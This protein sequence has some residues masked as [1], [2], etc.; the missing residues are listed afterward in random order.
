[1]GTRIVVTDLMIHPIAAQQDH[2]PHRSSLP[3][4]DAVSLVSWHCDGD[5]DCSDNSDETT[6]YI[7]NSDHWFHGNTMDPPYKL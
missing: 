4:T 2:A 3:E 6:L 1:M 5:N 7:Y